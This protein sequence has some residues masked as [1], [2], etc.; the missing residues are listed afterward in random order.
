[1]YLYSA[2]PPPLF[3]IINDMLHFNILLNKAPFTALKTVHVSVLCM[4]E[5]MSLIEAE[6]QA[7]ITDPIPF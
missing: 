6:Y 2:P 3:F 1:M 4:T 5:K 7:E